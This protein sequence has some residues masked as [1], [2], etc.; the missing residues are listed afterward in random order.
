MSAHCRRDETGLTLASMRSHS[1]RQLHA[2]LETEIVGRFGPDGLREV[3]FHEIV[4]YLRLTPY[5]IRQQPMRGLSFFA[6]AAMLL[7]A[8]GTVGMN[9]R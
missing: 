2:M 6:C 8:M 9:M 5:K 3:Y 1:L 4:N 7:A